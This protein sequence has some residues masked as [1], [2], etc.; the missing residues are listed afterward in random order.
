MEIVKTPPS[1][2]FISHIIRASTNDISQAYVREMKR[3]R[4]RAYTYLIWSETPQ[5]LPILISSFRSRDFV[6]AV[7]KS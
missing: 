6:Y 2:L 1:L 7:S 5:F 3:S 4:I